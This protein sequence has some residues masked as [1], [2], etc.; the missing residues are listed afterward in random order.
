M[1]YSPQMSDLRPPRSRSVTAAA[2]LMVL[3]GCFWLAIGGVFLWLLFHHE[4][5]TG[6]RKDLHRALLAILQCAASLA[7]IFVAFGVLFRRNWARISAIALAVFWIPF[8]LRFLEP[9]L[10][11]PSSLFPRGLIVPWALPILAG[12]TWLALLAPKKTRSEFLPPPS[13]K[14]Y[15]N[16]L[17]EGTPSSRP[18][19]ALALGNGTFELLPTKGYDPDDEQWEFLPGSLVRGMEARRDGE[20]YLLAVSLHS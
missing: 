10:R 12:M 20:P 11:I 14:I 19:L 7:T 16:L 17:G 5:G 4:G 1:V 2:V 8:G 15:V 9:F 3:T 13:V 6:S 18:T